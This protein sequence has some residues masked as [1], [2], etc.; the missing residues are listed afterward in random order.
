VSANQKI[1]TGWM[2]F[3]EHQG[4]E[5]FWMVWSAA[6]VPQL[7]AVKGVVNDK[8]KGTI[9]EEGQSKAVR[10]FLSQHSSRTQ[11]VETDK[12]RKHTIAKAL[13]AILVNPIEL[14][15]H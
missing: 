8:D 10:E 13:G 3:D 11:P 2:V 14:E 6:A 1:E 4:T 5:K 12:K 9:N 15:H 7:E